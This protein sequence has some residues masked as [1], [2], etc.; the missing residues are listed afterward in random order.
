M[1]DD[2]IEILLEIV[3]DGALEAVGSQKVPMPVRI[4]LGGLILG[5]ALAVVGLIAWTGIS[6]GSIL[7][8]IIAAVLLVGMTILTIRKRKK[9][10]KEQK[11]ENWL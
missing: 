5:L 1:L 8:V 7:L 2:I 3:L 4:L 6:N 11:E 9:F 10:K